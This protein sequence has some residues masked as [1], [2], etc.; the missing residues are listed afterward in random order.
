MPRS[1]R[2]FWIAAIIVAWAFDFLFW[3]HTPGLSLLI[4]VVLGLTAG[5]F[6]AFREQVRPSPLSYVLA[7]V[8][9]LLGLLTVLRSEML[10]IMLSTAGA[11]GGM[12][13]LVMTFRSGD[14]ARYRLADYPVAVVHMI[15]A[16]FARPARLTT[17][18]LKGK[19]SPGPRQ[20]GCTAPPRTC[21]AC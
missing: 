7:G 11:L 14:W 16:A 8:I 12:L 9:L 6:L 18:T 1:P 13:L 15:G 5:F 3:R 2:F 20:P 19:R 4:W 10:T 21:A 17:P